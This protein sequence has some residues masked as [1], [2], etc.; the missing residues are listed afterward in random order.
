[1][2]K[3]ALLSLLLFAF[4]YLYPQQAIDVSNLTLKVLD[5]N[6]INIT[7]EIT[8]T[9]DKPVSEVAG[10]IDLYDNSDRITEKK[11]LQIV[12][13]YDIPMQPGDTRKRET[14]TTQHPNLSGTARFRITHLR[15]FGEEEIYM[16][17][18]NCGELILKE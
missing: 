2:K 1:M 7:V 11:E 17:C 13:I 14:V 18:P 10:F 8:N 12:H 6:L 16:I 4:G 15:F 9:S 5:G 3:T